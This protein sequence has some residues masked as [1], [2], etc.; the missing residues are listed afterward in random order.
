MLMN[1]KLMLLLIMCM[2][3]LEIPVVIKMTE[4]MM[5]INAYWYI[6]CDEDA[7][8]EDVDVGMT[9]MLMFDDTRWK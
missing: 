4:T 7:A 1:V 6:C 8:G 3:K 2:L 9:E 5:I